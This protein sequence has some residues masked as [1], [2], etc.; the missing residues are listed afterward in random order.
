MEFQRKYR[1]LRSALGGF[2][3]IFVC[4]TFLEG[5]QSCQKNQ[6]KFL[7]KLYGGFCSDIIRDLLS[8]CRVAIFN[9]SE[10]TALSFGASSLRLI[11]R[12]Y[13]LGG[14]LVVPSFK[15]LDLG[16]IFC[17]LKLNL[18][19]VYIYIYICLPKFAPHG[20]RILFAFPFTAMY[21]SAADQ[22][23]SLFTAS[24]GSLGGYS[25]GSGL[26]VKFSYIY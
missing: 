7:C 5:L 14:T 26:G 2:Q 9:P 8:C 19:V 22:I 16:L 4:P 3:S 24:I 20:V 18:L 17:N 6:W 13:L 11:Y 23:R 10:F 12:C 21:L 25:L 1:G 15:A